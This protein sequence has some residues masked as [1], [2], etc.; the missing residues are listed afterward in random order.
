MNMKDWVGKLDAF[1][2]FN[3][4]EIL[5]DSGKI[6]HKTAVELAESEFEKHRVI[7]DR[8]IES[9][10]DSEVKRLLTSKKR[11]SKIASLRSQ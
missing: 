5:Q 4:K 1:L 8:M 6:S 2:K 10:F 11:K 9:D 3:E 7:Q